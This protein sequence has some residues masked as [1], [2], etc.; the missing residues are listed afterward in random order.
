M[1]ARMIVAFGG[2]MDL[3]SDNILFTQ[4][5]SYDY[6][7]KIFFFACTLERIRVWPCRP[8]IGDIMLRILMWSHCENKIVSWQYLAQQA[9]DINSTNENVKK[10][11]HS[12]R[13]YCGHRAPRSF[14]SLGLDWWHQQF[15]LLKGSFSLNYLYDGRMLH[16]RLDFRRS[17]CSACLPEKRR[18]DAWPADR[19]CAVICLCMYVCVCVCLCMYGRNLWRKNKNFKFSTLKRSR[20]R[21]QAE[22]NS[23]FASALLKFI[24]KKKK[25]MLPDLPARS[26]QASFWLVEM[27]NVSFTS[28]AVFSGMSGGSF[29]EAAAGNRA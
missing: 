24:L 21:S 26:G 6:I 11:A 1:I 23:A 9:Q 25:F 12:K 3:L 19:V 5:R 10:I 13:S 17:L 8:F 16:I 15:L 27:N 29:P 7:Y 4:C 2:G 22:S 18:L 14:N 20:T 28:P